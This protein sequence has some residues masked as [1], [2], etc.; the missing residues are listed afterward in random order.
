MA[1]ITKKNL[2]TS[3]PSRRVVSSLPLKILV[4]QERPTSGKSPY[5]DLAE[6]YGVE[7]AFLPFV[8]I[9]PVSIKDFRKQRVDL[10]GHTAVVLTSQTAIDHYFRVCES[11]RFTVSENMKYF[12]STERIAFY[13]QKYIVYRKRKIF[14]GVDS[15]AESLFIPIAKHPKERYLIPVSDIHN[16]TLFTLLDNKKIEYQKVVLF[17][18]VSAG[19]PPDTNINDYSM[20]LLF[21]PAGLTALQ[22]NCP[23]FE[24]GQINIGC[25]GSSTAKAITEAGL[26][27]DLLAP[28]PEALSMVTALEQ[29]LKKQLGAKRR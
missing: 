16:D 14:F 17:R 5:D 20:V 19:F 29:Y 9:E 21:T 7:I 8:R 3:T 6:K 28:T 10:A 12:C 25:F 11:M 4:S 15:K 27:V 23:N 1:V 18:T 13:L 26:R 24:Q 2:S 22:D